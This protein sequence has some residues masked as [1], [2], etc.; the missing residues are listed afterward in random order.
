MATRGTRCFRHVHASVKIKIL[1]HVFLVYSDSLVW[2]PLYSS[3]Y[4]LRG[5]G[6]IR[7]DWVSYNLNRSGLYLY[8]PSLQDLTIKYLLD[9]FGN[10]PPGLGLQAEWA[11]SWWAL[12]S[13]SPSTFDMV[14]MAPNLIGSSRVLGKWDLVLKIQAFLLQ[15]KL[16]SALSCL[17]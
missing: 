4:M 12:C 13:S 9:R 8:L 17:E 16:S 6:F 1:R 3:F 10:G 2:D 5:V 11:D 14:L 15:V 7:K